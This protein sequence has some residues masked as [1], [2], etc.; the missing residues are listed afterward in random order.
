MVRNVGILE[1]KTGSGIIEISS[2]ITGG[3]DAWKAAHQTEPQ[4][5]S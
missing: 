1:S 3:F 4:P 2:D 5:T